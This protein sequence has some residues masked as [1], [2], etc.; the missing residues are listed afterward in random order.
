MVCLC[1]DS[2][3]TVCVQVEHVCG[4]HIG[5]EAS[6]GQGAGEQEAGDS[7][8]L[9]LTPLPLPHFLLFLSLP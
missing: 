7:A 8:L 5:R 4:T 1:P 3:C 6:C 9:V 2:V